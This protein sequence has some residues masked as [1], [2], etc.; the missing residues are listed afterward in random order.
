MTEAEIDKVVA[1]AI[2]IYTERRP[3]PKSGKW[4]CN[5]T[6]NEKNHFRYLMKAKLMAALTDKERQKVIDHYKSIWSE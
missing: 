3:N 6:R 1:D 5:I 4:D 2:P